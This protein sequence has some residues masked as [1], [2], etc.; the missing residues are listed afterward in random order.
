[1]QKVYF[2]SGL[3]ADERVF[4]YLDLSFCEPVFI[5]WIKFLKDESLESYANRL[6]ASIPDQDPVVVGLSMGGMI[7]SI[8]ASK[9][10]N[11]KAV[12]ISS[13]KNSGE[14][15]PYLR[16]GKFAPIYKYFTGK[17]SLLMR[18]MIMT[19]FGSM[20]KEQEDLLMQL[21]NETDH[22]FMHNAI[23]AILAWKSDAGISPFNIKHIH[24]TADMMLP[25]KY[26]KADYSVKGGTHA[27]VVTKPDEVSVLLK[28]ALGV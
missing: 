7:A 3:G 15:P 18:K 8:M 10:P 28:K 4:K 2:I 25:Y 5:P 27:M 24:G 22:E 16:A 19:T 20:T 11:M 9:E 14:F 26:V 12:I 21:M 13:N 23:R 1:M 17:P 6:R